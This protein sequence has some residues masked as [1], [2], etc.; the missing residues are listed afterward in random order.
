MSHEE[1]RF[2]AHFRAPV[3]D[4]TRDAMWA[5]IRASR[6][7]SRDAS[8]P[9]SR[10]RP[11]FF[12]LGG[13]AAA[14]ALV[15]AL[16][17][18]VSVRA[19]V[20]ALPEPGPLRLEMGRAE[21]PAV[22]VSN[23]VSAVQ[24]EDHSRVAL[25]GAMQLE[26]LENTATSFALKQP[27]G[28]AHYEVSPGG[29]RRWS[30]ETPLARIEV[31][32]TEFEVHADATHV[33]VAVQHGVVLV[34]GELVPEH[35]QRLTAGQSLELSKPDLLRFAQA[36][37]SLTPTK[38]ASS[39]PEKKQETH[40]SKVDA[41]WRDADAARARN[42]HTAA[43]AALSDIVREHAGDE[44]AGLAALTLGRMRMDLLSEP[45]QAA[46]DLRTALRLGLSPALQEDAMLRRCECLA[47]SGQ[48]AAAS[49]EAQTWVRA[50]P[51]SAPLFSRWAL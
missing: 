13:I 49:L 25:R 26:V 31:V 21:V 30:V 50:H 7:A 34:R 27:I 43:V 44:R 9:A 39:A 36:T 1:P 38:E 41:L 17:A 16:R 14:A 22:L 48:M 24:F 32:G 3:D 51:V 29:P 46:A 12:A 6:K 19:P 8:G 4:E 42:D 10:S 11:A 33:H 28:D 37:E 15:W 2:A 23:A 5:Q 45:A 20:L 35:V 47:A 40:L 18:P